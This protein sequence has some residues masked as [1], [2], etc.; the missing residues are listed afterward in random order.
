VNCDLGLQPGICLGPLPIRF[1]GIIIVLGIIVGGFVAAREARFRGEN[2]DRIWDALV[3]IAIAGI[4]G[5]RLYHVFSTPAGCTETAPMCGWPWYSQ[6]PLDALKIWN[7]GLGIFGA[8][9]AGGLVV[10]IYARRH[11]LSLTRYLDIA[12][13]ALLIGQAIGRWGNFANQELYGP[14]TTLPWGIPIDAAHRYGAFTNLA[15]YPVATTRFQPDF[16][17]ESLLNVIGFVVL[18]IVA[19]RFQSRLKDGDVFLLYLIWY[20]ANRILVESLRPDAWTVAGG[21]AT[22]QLVSLIL[23]AV[24][25][26]GLVWRHRH[27]RQTRISST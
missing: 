24:A 13:P 19:R 17:Y 3:W 20:P 21:L 7:G 11:Q 14:P 16:L 15:Q 1:Y 10:L 27:D 25:V 12:A 8:L 2:P 18:T 6:H 9:L 5:A 4:I 23:I 26:L 22:A